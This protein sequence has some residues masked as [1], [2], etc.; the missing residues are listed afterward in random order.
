M[1]ITLLFLSIFYT[2]LF[3]SSPLEQ[4][5]KQLNSHLDSIAFT[6]T[7]E[8]KVTLYYLILSTHENINSALLLDEKRFE[9]LEQLKGKTL[10]TFTT[11]RENNDQLDQMTIDTL[12]KLYL[13]MQEEGKRL[14]QSK[15]TQAKPLRENTHSTLQKESEP[16]FWIII[17]VVTFIGGLIIGFFLFRPKI[18]SSVI[19]EKHSSNFLEENRYEKLFEELQTLQNSYTSLEYQYEQ[20]LKKVDLLEQQKEQDRYALES[21]QEKYESDTSKERE[22]AKELHETLEQLEEEKKE[23]QTQLVKQETHE[24]QSAQIQERLNAL[25]SQSNEIHTI[26]ALI[27]DIADQT[28]LLA[29][30]AAIEAARAGEHGRGFAVVADEVRKLAERTQK[31]LGDAKVQISSLVD[32]ISHIKD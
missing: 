17:A 2:T 19:E 12:K 31:A 5:Y 30:N 16:F 24:I 20:E 7:P 28:N 27:S 26:L 18:D 4:S 9:K 23:L 10:Q 13:T 25:H 29:L 15:T 32:A 22:F 14:L 21:L 3:A 1:K 6:L 11:L 8:E